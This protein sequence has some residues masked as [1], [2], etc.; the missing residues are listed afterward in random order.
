MVPKQTFT[1]RWQG[2]RLT[3]GQRTWLRRILE[4]LLLFLG[5]LAAIWLATR[6]D[7][8]PQLI[9]IILVS[10]IGLQLS[11]PLGRSLYS[12][13]L[14]IIAPASLLV[15]GLPLTLLALGGSFLLAEISRPLWQ[16]LWSNT[17]L[18]TTPGRA[19]AGRVLCHLLAVTAASYVYRWR[20]GSAPLTTGPETNLLAAGLL[21]LLLL[22]LTYATLFFLAS[23][24]LAR[25]RRESF[26]Q[27]FQEGGF[28]FLTAAYFTQPFALLGAAVFA[29]LGLPGFVVFC[30]GIGAFAVLTW[31][32][33]QRNFALHQQLAQ[34]ARLNDIGLSLRET[35]DL[36]TVL[37][38][39]YEQVNALLPAGYFY[40]A[41]Q[42]EDGS[43]Q[44][45][46]LVENGQIIPGRATNASYQLDDFT[47]WVAS[48]RRVLNIDSENIHFATQH[49]L[50]P[51][52]PR[53]A[54]W[55]GVPMT[56]SQQVTG[57]IVLQRFDNEE[58]F[59]LWSREVLLAIA[60]QASAAVQN[61]RLYNEVVRLYNR[62]DEA[63]AERVQQLQALLDSTHEGVLMLDTTGRV[64]L[65]NPV[66]AL[67]LGQPRTTL[68]Q[69]RLDPAGS[70]SA[71]GYRPEQLHLLLE[72]LAQPTPLPPQKHVFE[73]RL[74]AEPGSP[75]LVR[76]FLERS[77][78]PVLAGSQQV[79]GWLMVFND[80]TEVQERAEWRTNATRMI[81]HDL[82]NP[83]TTLISTIDLMADGL[84]TQTDLDLLRLTER[85][86]RG[87]ADMLDMVDSLMDMTR[88]EAGQLVLDAEAMRLP[89]L[90]ARVL[91]HLEPLSLQKQIAVTVS[92][93]PDL[94]AVWADEEI[95]R[96]ILVNLLDNALK[97]TPAGGTITIELAQEP[98]A[99]AE[100]EPGIRCIISDTGPGIPAI[101]KEQIFDRF[102]R[103]NVGGAQV[104]GTG[105][106]LT[107]CKLAIEAHNG[108]IW[109]EDTPG[110]G[111]RFVF[112]LPGIPI[113]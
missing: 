11:L 63:L 2:N 1:G 84:D 31:I 15:L 37:V 21:P 8:A 73:T 51:P 22:V 109:V 94:P 23:L 91:E 40:I 46:L 83:I 108:Q 66:A 110:R 60:G 14:P 69:Q 29:T 3:Q 13:I 24:A 26:P 5:L 113:F 53:P 62:T 43:W 107:F 38:R 68:Q 49:Q 56:S 17:S 78:A 82:R 100:S 58:P 104:R 52:S 106:G 97:F 20:G 92:S 95:L 70:A 103:V 33:W 72:Q 44:R 35:L 18:A 55:L 111:S 105:L 86:R 112:T 32:S 101:H 85:A 4:W 41:L 87:C 6:S 25:L 47:H 88:M 80:V 90:L 67:L 16:P 89:R 19:R 65:V 71:L 28:F 61:A 99:P 76:R 36:P 42:Q 9:L 10:V 102:V 48:R 45:P 12:P 98:P 75:E 77:E 30:V 96:R 81:V 74:P 34:F 7:E 54:A 93:P 27:F 57:V 39:T 59:S 50:Q 79:L 64:V